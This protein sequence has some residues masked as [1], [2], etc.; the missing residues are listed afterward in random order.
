MR[1]VEDCRR[2]LRIVEGRLPPDYYFRACS[3]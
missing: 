1:P 3:G 2:L